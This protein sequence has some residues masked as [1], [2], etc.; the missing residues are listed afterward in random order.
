M[1]RL[2]R[3][4]EAGGYSGIVPRVKGMWIIKRKTHFR[5]PV[6]ESPPTQVGRLVGGTH[7]TE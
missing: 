3:G 1:A 7:K 2:E 5:V 4:A 6:G